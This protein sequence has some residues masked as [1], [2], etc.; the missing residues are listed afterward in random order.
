[1]EFDEG[2]GDGF[3]ASRLDAGLE[4][5]G[6]PGDPLIVKIFPTSWPVPVLE[7]ESNPTNVPAGEGGP[8][9]RM[10]S[11]AEPPGDGVVTDGPV[12]RTLPAPQPD[13]ALQPGW[14]RRGPSIAQYH[15]EGGK[16]SPEPSQVLSNILE[17]LERAH[18]M[19]QEAVQTEAFPEGSS[20]SLPVSAEETEAMQATGTAVLSKSGEDHH[21]HI[22]K[23]FR[24]DSDAT[25]PPVGETTTRDCHPQRPASGFCPQDVRRRCMI[26]TAATVISLPLMILLCCVVIQ[27]RRKR[28]QRLSA[29]EGAQRETGGYPSRPDSRTSRPRTPESGT[30]HQELPF[31]TGKPPRPPSPR[32]PRPPSPSPAALKRW[33][34]SSRPQTQPNQPPPPPSLPP[35]ALQRWHQPSPLQARL[36]PKRPPRPP[37]PLA[38]PSGKG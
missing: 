11:R 38:R 22:H 29:A 35:P 27:R 6:H 7:P 28:K 30:Q 24:A 20:G 25:A 1:M 31:R 12:G 32:P 10:G 8:A 36:Q 2:G 19:D 3:P 23:F 9:S 4:P 34:Q 18:E 21:S 37:S 33:N 13:P 26:G 17:E 14:R 5:L 16:K 15:A